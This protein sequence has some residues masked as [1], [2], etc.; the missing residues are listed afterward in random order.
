L[1]FTSSEIW[2]SLNEPNQWILFDLKEKSFKNQQIRIQIHYLYI[3]RQ[4]TLE[5]SNDNSQWTTIH[6]QGED[7]RCKSGY[8]TMICDINCEK[9]F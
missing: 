4:W 7:E 9:P 2:H 5:G 3:G 8:Y 1:N 6:N